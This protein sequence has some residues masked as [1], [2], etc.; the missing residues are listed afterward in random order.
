MKDRCLT[1]EEISAYIDGV[2]SAEERAR[3]EFHLAKCSFC[4]HN[5][6]ELKQLVSANDANPIAL[7]EAAIAQAE[8]VIEEQSAS[9]V[10][11]DIAVVLRNGICKILGSTGNLLPPRKLSPVVLRRQRSP[12]TITRISKSVSGFL[13]TVELTPEKNMVKPEVIVVEE[14]TSQ[15]PDGLK[16]KLYSPG[17]CETSYSTDGRITFRPVANGYYRIEIEEIGTIGLDVKES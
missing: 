9:P 15:K 1:D 8:A 17:A 16:A 12:R 2:V 5:V 6:A 11:F 4:L 14:S 7:P 3:I 10:H 13:V